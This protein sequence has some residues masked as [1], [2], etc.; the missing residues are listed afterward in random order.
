MPSIRETLVAI[1][2]ADEPDYDRAVALGTAALRAIG[3][4]IDDEPHLAASA[5]YVA[6]QIPT[7]ESL[8]VIARAARCQDA[9]VRATAAGALRDWAQHPESADDLEAAFDIVAPLLDDADPSVRKFANRAL[10]VL[11]A[12]GSAPGA[13]RRQ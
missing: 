9:V 13:S 1:F 3:E 11:P 4:M 6:G 8:E 7:H 10:A 5:V 2:A 12:H